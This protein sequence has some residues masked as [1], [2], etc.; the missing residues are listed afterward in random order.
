MNGYVVR[1]LPYP[2]TEEFVNIGVVMACPETGT[3]DFRIET[4]RRERITGFFPELEAETEDVLR[5]ARA[6]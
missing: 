6:G 5:F 1:F 3:F 4:R 2:E